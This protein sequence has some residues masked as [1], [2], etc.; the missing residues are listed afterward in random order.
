MI[1][2]SIGLESERARALFSMARLDLCGAACAGSFGTGM[3]DDLN[4]SSPNRFVRACAAEAVGCMARRAAVIQPNS[5]TTSIADSHRFSSTAP[6]ARLV[7]ILLPG[8]SLGGEKPG[9]EGGAGDAARHFS[10]PVVDYKFTTRNMVREN[11][12]VSALSLCANAAELSAVVPEKDWLKLVETLE[13]LT[14]A[15]V[16]ASIHSCFQMPSCNAQKNPSRVDECVV[17][18]I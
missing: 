18:L 10:N 8:L 13:G 2:W 6:Y 17:N 16:R 14:S 5:T 3:S 15:R 11:A 7:S 4:L 9:T 1:V 12:S